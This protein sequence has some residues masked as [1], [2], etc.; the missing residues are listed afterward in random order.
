MQ[1]SSLGIFRGRQIPGLIREIH[2]D[3]AGHQ[4]IGAF[5]ATDL[6]FSDT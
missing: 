4:D 5:S 6:V 3:R 1:R 2:G